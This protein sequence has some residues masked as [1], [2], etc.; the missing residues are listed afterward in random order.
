MSASLAACL[1]VVSFAAA[2]LCVDSLKK[3]RH[4]P[5]AALCAVCFALWMELARYDHG[6]GDVLFSIGWVG[7]PIVAI[8]GGASWGTRRFYGWP[9]LGP[10]PSRAGALAA[11]IVLGVLVGSQVKVGDV[12]TSMQGADALRATWRQAGA[13]AAGGFPTTIEAFAPDAPRTSMGLFAPPAFL[14]GLDEGQP[15]IGFPLGGDSYMVRPLPKTP[16]GA[17]PSWRRQRRAPDPFPAG[18]TP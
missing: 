16:D 1:L 14:Y 3:W 6:H 13:R 4:A 11:F 2:S 5:L 12:E 10:H 17:E 18:W 8:F 9:D 7:A 15:V